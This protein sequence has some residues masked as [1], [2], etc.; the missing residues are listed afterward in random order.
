VV[1]PVAP[2]T[3]GNVVSPKPALT[4]RFKVRTKSGRAL[5]GAQV[6]VT[7]AGNARSGVSDGQGIARVPLTA[8]DLQ[9]AGGS[10]AAEIKLFHFGPDPGPGGTVKAGAFTASPAISQD[11][12][13]PKGDNIQSD[14]A[15]TYFDCVLIDGVYALAAATSGT[16]TRRLTDDEVQKELMKH[17]L[18][19]DLTLAAG[20]EF[21]V[22]HDTSMGEFDTCDLSKCKI[23]TPAKT[24]WVGLASPTVS[25]VTFYA[26]IDFGVAQKKKTDKIPGHHFVRDTFTW[27]KMP[28]RQLDQRHVVG[29][30]RMCKT[31]N[32]DHGVV[33]I[34]TQGVNGDLVRKDCHGYGRALDF[35]GLSTSDPDPDTKK[36][37]VRMG[38]DFIVY[39]HWGLVPMWN[40]TSVAAN[41][42]DSSQWTRQAGDDGADYTTDPAGTTKPLRYRMDPAPFQDPVP[43]IDPPDADLS[44]LLASVAQHFQ[45]AGPMFKAIFDFATAEYS[46]TNSQLGPL[47][48]GTDGTPTEINDQHGHYILH[49]DYGKPNAA[50]AKNG[51]QAHVNHLHFQVGPTNYTAAR[52]K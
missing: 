30:A 22:A 1:D 3:P 33:A 28:M 13:D 4:L 29:L 52:Q 32:S 41:P 20:S 23:T 40:Y 26:L 50:G 14:K 24:D 16:V 8:S 34:Y 48:S 9:G 43:A 45:A 2:N 51:R 17:H 44:S 49:P 25:S 5:R 36:M 12:F 21:V 37:P 35:G 7:V 6:T 46:D 39:L 47:T 38:V 19:G 11:G 42:S 31:L 27:G 18:D 15:G 10:V